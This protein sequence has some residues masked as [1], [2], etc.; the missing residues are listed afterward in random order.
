M[1][2]IFYTDAENIEDLLE[3]LTT[4]PQ[5]PEPQDCEED[6]QR[7]AIEDPDPPGYYEACGIFRVTIEQLERPIPPRPET[8]VR[9]ETDEPSKE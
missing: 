6:L 2:H 9:A 4:V 5:M 1:K 8:P 3:L 7:F